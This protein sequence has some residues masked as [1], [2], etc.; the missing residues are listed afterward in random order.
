MPATESI[1]AL[2]AFLPCPTPPAWLDWAQQHPQLLL[3]DHAH[4]EKKAAATALNLMFRY[5]ER[6]ELLIK[7]A[8]LAREELLH[9]EQVLSLIQQRGIV[10]RHLPASRYAS[11]LRQAA[12]TSE[13]NKLIDILI[14]GALIEARSCERFHAL[15]NRVDP[16]LS[17]YYRYLIKSEARHFEDYLALARLYAEQP[18]DQRIDYFCQIEQHLIESGDNEFRFHSGVPENHA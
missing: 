1:T 12:S 8:Q 11:E 15:S 6:T 13:P 3:I 14:I 9:F 18:I 10:Y 7:L 4:C 16:E 5:V 2:H 17:R